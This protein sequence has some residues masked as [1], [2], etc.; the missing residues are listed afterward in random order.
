MGVPTPRVSYEEYLRLQEESEVRL[1]YLRGEIFAMAGGTREHSALAT[2][3]IAAFMSARRG[4]PCFPYGS[5]LRVRIPETDRST[6]P[7]ITVVCGR[8]EHAP[9]DRDAVTNPAVIVEVLSESTEKSDRGEKWAHYRR[10]ASLRDFILAAQDRPYIE[11][12]RR[13]DGDRWELRELG[14]GDTILTSAGELSVDSIYQVL[15]ANS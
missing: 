12:Y 10:I 1:E 14:A 4:G 8:A 6:Y 15:S 5:D 3:F 11:H 2:G 7:D 9:E 13:L